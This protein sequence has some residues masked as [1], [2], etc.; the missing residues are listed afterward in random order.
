MV[1]KSAGNRRPPVRA[2][3]ISGSSAFKPAAPSGAARLAAAEQAADQKSGQRPRGPF[4]W[5]RR[6]DGARKDGEVAWAA[7][8][9]HL[10][11][12]APCRLGCRIAK[13]LPVY[14][15]S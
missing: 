12:P 2:A 9:I 10:A 8:G 1:R 5:R 11:F 3:A 7:T 6:G 15:L 13:L 4:C 14:A